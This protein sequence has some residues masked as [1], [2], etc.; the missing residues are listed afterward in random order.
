MLP[1][2]NAYIA[3]EPKTMNP[4][5]SLFVR[6]MLLIV[7][8][9]GI[10]ALVMDFGLHLVPKLEPWDQAISAAVNPDTPI[11]ALDA[12]FRA[13]SDYGNFLIAMPLVS[14]S[15]AVGLYRLTQV[16]VRAAWV[17]GIVASAL[18]AV[19]IY[20]IHGEL[21]LGTQGA[22]IAA[23]LAPILIVFGAAL[24]RAFAL[25]AKRWITGL[26][27]AEVVTLVGLWF[28]HLVWWNKELVEANYVLLPVMIAAFGGAVYAFHCMDERGLGRFVGVFWLVLLNIILVDP[29]ATEQSKSAIGRPRPLNDARKPW[30]EQLRVIPEEKLKGNNSFPSGHTSGTFALITPLFWWVRDRRARAGIL[31]CGVLQAASRVY[32]VAHFAS[33][34]IVGSL[35]GFGTGT[36]VFFLLGGPSRRAPDRAQPA[37]ATPSEVMI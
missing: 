24:P 1:D 23:A 35:L 13:V 20:L 11:V 3:P 36:L 29:I 32:V 30:N 7:A 5:I 14:L 15:V 34:V 25:P 28:A 17:W 8:F 31:T 27:A 21:E 18:W 33:D 4:K 12:F 9:R 6:W 19:V 10:W 26:L 2:L 22:I 37:A 16:S